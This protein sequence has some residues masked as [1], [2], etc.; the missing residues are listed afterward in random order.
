LAPDKNVKDFLETV[1]KG[2]FYKKLATM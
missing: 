1:W 2:F